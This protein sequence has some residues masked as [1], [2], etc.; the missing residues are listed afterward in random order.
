MFTKCFLNIDTEMPIKKVCSTIFKATFDDN[1]NIQVKPIALIPV[2]VKAEYAKTGSNVVEEPKTSRVEFSS[3]NCYEKRPNEYDNHS[4]SL[5][6]K[7]EASEQV[8]E[9]D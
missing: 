3:S 1:A 9:S 2:D 7:N 5:S 6:G 4:F 8:S